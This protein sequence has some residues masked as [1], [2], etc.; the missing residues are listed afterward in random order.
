MLNGPAPK[1]LLAMEKP[2]DFD[3]VMKTN[4]GFNK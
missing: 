2:S 1:F 4:Y 3:D